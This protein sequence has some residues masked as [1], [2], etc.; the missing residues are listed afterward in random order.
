M[1]VHAKEDVEVNQKVGMK[2]SEGK[3]G[4][5]SYFESFFQLKSLMMIMLGKA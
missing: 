5:E 3:K 4:G 1:E 2:P